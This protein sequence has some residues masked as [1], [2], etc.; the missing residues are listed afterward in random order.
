[1]PRWR[2]RV[3]LEEGLKLD[4]NR[5][6]AQGLVLYARGDFAPNCAPPSRARR[7]RLGSDFK[8]S[9]PPRSHSSTRA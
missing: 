8:R 7:K 1:M 6:I 9:P 4:L 3:R 5:L 2:Q